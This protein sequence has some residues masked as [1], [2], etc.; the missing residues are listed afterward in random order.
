MPPPIFTLFISPIFVSISFYFRFLIDFRFLL[1]PFHIFIVSYSPI[2]TISFFFIFI[3]FIS[4]HYAIHIFI[5]FTYFFHLLFFIALFS[6]M[7][8]MLYCASRHFHYFHLF[9]H[10]WYFRH[11]FRHWLSLLHFHFSSFHWLFHFI[12]I[13]LLISSFWFSLLR[14]SATLRQRRFHFFWYF[15]PFSF[16]Y[17]RHTFRH[18]FHDIALLP[19]F[20]IFASYASVSASATFISLDIDWRLPIFRAAFIDDIFFFIS[21]DYWC[22][23]DF[24]CFFAAIISRH[25]ACFIHYFLLIFI[26]FAHAI[27]HWLSRYAITPLSRHWDYAILLFDIFAFAIT[28]PFF[29]LFSPSPGFSACRRLPPRLRLLRQ[30][31]LPCFHTPLFFIIDADISPLIH[32]FHYS[33]FFDIFHLLLLISLFASAIL[34]FWAIFSIFLRLFI[35]SFRRFHYFMPSF[36]TFFIAMIFFSCFISPPYFDFSSLYYDFRRLGFSAFFVI[37]AAILRRWLFFIA[38]AASKPPIIVFR[39][40]ISLIFS[41]FIFCWL[42]S[43][44]AA[45]SCHFLCC[46]HFL[47]VFSTFSHSSVSPDIYFHFRFSPEL[48]FSPDAWMAFDHFDWYLFSI[49][50]SFSSAA[51]AIVSF[52]FLLHCH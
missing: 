43:F 27:F 14:F 50:F 25:A 1:P 41:F 22:S 48:F 36:F 23:P 34:Y 12:F 11:Y 39:H 18:H 2:F 10:Y 35:A 6:P 49:R 29:V 38:D 44:H 52:H 5:F 16:H 46:L 42:P 20:A 32:A 8:P 40:C 15:S 31:V 4:L 7:L 45:S 21:V 47:S 9:S 51:F 30:I 33:H 26:F 28:P 37:S 24:H 3:S 13:S 17:F 19:A